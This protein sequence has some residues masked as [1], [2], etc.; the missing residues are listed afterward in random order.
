MAVTCTFLMILINVEQICTQLWAIYKSSVK[1]N[2]HFL[3]L[4]PLSLYCWVVR[5]LHIFCSIRKTNCKHFPT[6][7]SCFVKKWNIIILKVSYAL[8]LCTKLNTSFHYF[9]PASY[10]FVIE[11]KTFLRFWQNFYIYKLFSSPFINIKTAL[12]FQYFTL[13]CK[14]ALSINL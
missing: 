5:V 8:H 14:A 7:L 1:K 12:Q 6:T 3:T 9:F 4:F 11:I 10:I 2:A 13:L